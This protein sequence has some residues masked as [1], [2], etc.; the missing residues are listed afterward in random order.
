MK[1]FVDRG[2]S[3][4]K[5]DWLSSRSSSGEGPDEVTVNDESVNQNYNF[6]SSGNSNIESQNSATQLQKQDSNSASMTTNE[7]GGL[8][9]P[10]ITDVDDSSKLLAEADD[11]NSKLKELNI[12]FEDYGTQDG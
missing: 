5:H 10:N 12:S 9:N 6:T 4:A 1:Q 3:M 8:D 2:D 11:L 7:T